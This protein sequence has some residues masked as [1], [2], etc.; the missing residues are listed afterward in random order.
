VSGKSP[1]I[2]FEDKSLLI[3]DKPSGWVV[4]DASTVGETPT[5]QGW[6]LEN[7]DFSISK[8]KELR[9]G[10]VHRLDKET[11]GILLVAKKRSVFRALQ[12]QFK[13]RMVSKKYI[14][15]VH[16]KLK[17]KSG[18]VNASLGRL[19]WNRERFGVLAKGR[20]ALTLYKC[21]GVYEREG[22]FFSMV[23]VSPKTG[24][25]H[26]IRVHMKYLGN[27][28]VSDT[29]YAGRKTSREDRKWC[30]RLFLHASW[31]S[32]VHPVGGACVEY[33]SE[34]SED[35]KT[36]VGALSKVD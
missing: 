28:V 10:I 23:E 8:S 22:N 35:L 32:F 4:N 2:I 7:C 27:P 18:E 34:L 33:E 11:S 15:L 6:I 31:I 17:E 24:R 21:I 29:F 1:G 3:L 14:A 30:G 5:I 16:G 20:D 25:T 9:S 19:P 12:G 26:Q 36:V 13:E